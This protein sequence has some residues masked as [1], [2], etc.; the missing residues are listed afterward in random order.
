M[1]TLL[2]AVAGWLAFSLSP[3]QKIYLAILAPV[4]VIGIAAAL[5]A[6]V[7]R[8]LGQTKPLPV[9]LLASDTSAYVR[10]HNP[11]FVELM[12]D[13]YQAADAMPPDATE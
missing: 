12:S 13:F 3:F 11:R 2:A 4:G 9:Q 6:V 7:L 10:F 8:L 5:L 1:A